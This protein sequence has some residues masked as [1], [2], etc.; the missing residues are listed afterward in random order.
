MRVVNPVG[1]KIDSEAAAN[2]V[3]A[4][5]CGTDSSFAVASTENG[6]DTCFHCGCA[7]DMIS[8]GNTK[9]HATITIRTSEL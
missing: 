1:R 5:Y 7:C 2:L 8:S 3:R 4:C 9:A 6:S